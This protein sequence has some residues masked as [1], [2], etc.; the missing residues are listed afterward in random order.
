MHVVEAEIR[1]PLILGHKSYN[2]ITEDVCRPIESRANSLWYMLFGLAS[3]LALWGLGNIL[4]TV[5]VGIGV[6]THAAGIPRYAIISA[7]PH[8]PAVVDPVIFVIPAQVGG[9]P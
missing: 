8:P 5:G 4:Y 7:E 9:V 3:I 1:E 2:D 6:T